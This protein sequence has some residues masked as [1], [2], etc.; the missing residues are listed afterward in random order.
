MIKE[1][2]KE[3]NRKRACDVNINISGGSRFFPAGGPTFPNGWAIAHLANPLEPPL[4]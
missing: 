2:S 1:V 3:F 4:T